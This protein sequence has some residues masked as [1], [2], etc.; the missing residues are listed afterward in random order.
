MN[1][2]NAATGIEVEA[3]FP[4]G[5][6]ECVQ[7][8][9]WFEERGFTV[10]RQ[11]PVHRIHVYFDDNGRLQEAGCRL[12]CVIAVGEWCRYDFKADDPSG[13]G[14]TLEISEKGDQPIPIVQAVKKLAVKLSESP[15]RERLLSIEKSARIILVA[16]GCHKK[17]I[18]RLGELAMELTWDTLVPLDT[19][20]ALSE[21]EIE[22]IDGLREEF[23]LWVATLERELSLVREHRSKLVRLRSS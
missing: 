18:L 10:E 5:Q 19:G 17:A 3:K 12:R 11:E 2:R 1:A 22:W 23:D 4:G 14:N 21:I 16:T 15:E 7:I 8:I 13:K 9:G 20:I 6:R